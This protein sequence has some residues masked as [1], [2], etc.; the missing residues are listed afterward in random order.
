MLDRAG[1]WAFRPLIYLGLLAGMRGGEILNLQWDEVDFLGRKIYVL[2]GKSKDDRAIPMCEELFAFL[3]EWKRD[4]E[5][6]PL[7]YH[8][9][10]KQIRNYPFRDVK[11]KAKLDGGHCLRRTFA[12]RLV[13][14]GVSLYKVS[15]LLGH[16]S[17]ET[18]M[19]YIYL[20]VG[21]EELTEAL[22][23]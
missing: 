9:R 12:T 15:R 7:V 16:Q 18:T 13:E 19:T 8:N 20:E 3:R 22:S 11:K 14:R 2:D 5:H 1:E 6:G 21:S 10:G 23:F 4:H 17:I